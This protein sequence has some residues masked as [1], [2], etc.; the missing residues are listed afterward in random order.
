M[1]PLS[2]GALAFSLC[3]LLLSGCSVDAPR[4]EETVQ[5]SVSDNRLRQAQIDRAAALQSSYPSADIPDVSLVRMVDMASWPEAMAQCLTENGFPSDVQDGGVRTMVAEGQD[6]A[7]AIAS[8][9]CSVEYPL[10]PKYEVSLTESQLKILYEYYTG[11]LTACLEGL[12]YFVSDPPSETVFID[13]YNTSESWSPLVD[14]ADSM[15]PEQW[16]KANSG[17]ESAPLDL[18]Y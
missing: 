14:I 2:R 4:K 12:G 13:R 15:S 1:S 6:E 8:Y 11:T 3:V 7:K 17:C 10:D 18:L 9:R 5:G 16:T